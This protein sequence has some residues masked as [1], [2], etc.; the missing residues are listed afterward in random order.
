MLCLV[1]FVAFAFS[2]ACSRSRAPI[3]FNSALCARVCI[4]TRVRARG[5]IAFSQLLY[6]HYYILLFWIG[7]M[8][9]SLIFSCCLWCSVAVIF[10]FRSLVDAIT[11]SV[12]ILC[13]I[14]LFCALTERDHVGFFFSSLECEQAIWWK[15]KETEE[16]RREKENTE[17]TRWKKK[18]NVDR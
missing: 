6:F 2:S 11:L 3:P 1:V 12:R 8:C 4:D 13:F 7:F 18:A 5:V 14:P 16:R 15:K 10:F 17:T 9:V